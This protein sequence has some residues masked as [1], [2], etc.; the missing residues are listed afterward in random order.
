MAIE[1]ESNEE[2]FQW[3]SLM[4]QA[5]RFTYCL[6][7][8]T[9][10]V[11]GTAIAISLGEQFFFATAKHEINNNNELEILSRG[12]VAPITTSDFVAKHSRHQIDIGLLE[13][14][15]DAADRFDFADRTQLLPKIDE[16][17]E[18]PTLVVG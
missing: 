12:P 4:H 8:R 2:Q 11:I 10:E 3:Q 5:N 6:I 17:C 14:K 15:P 7:D 9:K 16:N 18:W 13:I 1:N